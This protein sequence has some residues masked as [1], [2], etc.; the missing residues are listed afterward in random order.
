MR[1]TI[2]SDLHLE[3][4]LC[5]LLNTEGG[6]VIILAGD[7]IPVVT[8]ERSVGGHINFK[9]FFD[10]VCSEWEHVIM[11]MGNHEHYCYDMK[12]TKDTFKGLVNRDNFHILENEILHIKG[13]NF[14]GC[15]LWTSIQDPLAQMEVERCM[16][17][18]RQILIDGE[19]LTVEHTNQLNMESV[20]YITHATKGLE[21]VFV[22]THHAP[23]FKSVHPK[24]VDD[25]YINQAFCNNLDYL[26]ESRDNIKYWVHGHTHHPKDYCIGNTRVL[27]NPRGYVGYECVAE[28]YKPLTVEIEY[29]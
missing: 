3:V 6:D 25:V 13:V 17:D 4:G 11:V 27:C 23:S 1:V 28:D 29:V 15:T 10:K 7:I 19:K 9:H 24:Y 26:I 5:E 14:L 21:N 2:A 12:R 16:N 22:V 20:G 18:Y 8:L